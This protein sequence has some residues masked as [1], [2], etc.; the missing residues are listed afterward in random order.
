MAV[1]AGELDRRIQI[2]LA[3]EIKDAAGD[4]VPAWSDAFRLFAKKT[5]RSGFET[6]G[7]QQ[8]IRAGDT[9]FEIRRSARAL[10]ITPELHRVVY[11]GRIYQ[12]V[13]IQEGKSRKDSLQLLTSSRPDGR[14][15]RGRENTTGP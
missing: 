4:M 5:D 13:G 8:L 3:T 1:S 11:D 7:A 2:Q 9:V 14:G 15:D 10:A 6:N 12:I